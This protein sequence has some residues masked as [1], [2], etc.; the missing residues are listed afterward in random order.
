M[1]PRKSTNAQR[2]ISAGG[3]VTI[4]AATPHPCSTGDH[5]PRPER[6]RLVESPIVIG[7][8]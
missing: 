2:G 6:G 8:L 5:I 1:A 3:V 7:Q 4:D